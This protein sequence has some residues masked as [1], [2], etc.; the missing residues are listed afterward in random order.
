MWHEPYFFIKYVT[1]ALLLHKIC[2]MSLTSSYIINANNSSNIL[3]HYNYGEV[4]II[5]PTLVLAESGINSEQFSL[6]RPIYIKK[7]NF[8]TVTSG[9]N[10]KSG[11]NFEWSLLRNFTVLHSHYNWHKNNHFDI[12]HKTEQLSTYIQQYNFL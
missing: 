11:L 4:P 1:W 12:L 9:L 5:R 3:W 7:M 8:G 6:M 2:D 10:S